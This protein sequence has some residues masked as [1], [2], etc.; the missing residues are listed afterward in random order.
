M[1]IH[2]LALAIRHA[3]PRR[4]RKASSDIAEDARRAKSSIETAMHSASSVRF[5]PRTERLDTTIKLLRASCDH[6]R[7][8]TALLEINYQDFG[9]SAMALHRSQIEQFLRGAFFSD[10]ATDGELSYFLQHDEMPKRP[11]G[12]LGLRRISANDLAVIA[13]DFL[14]L[15]PR[16][17]LIS[18]VRNAWSPLCGMVHGG[19]AVMA[20]YQ[21]GDEQIGFQADIS[22]LRQVLDN[23]TVIAN[24]SLTI[25]VTLSANSAQEQSELLRPTSEEFANYMLHIASRSDCH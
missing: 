7:A 13:A 4:K 18:M 17:K 1:R 3:I 23:A 8:L 25:L 19:R 10:P 22:P 16:D 14:K 12:N 9:G 5:P 21:D 2:P 24:F 6:A 15:N 20:T 11:C